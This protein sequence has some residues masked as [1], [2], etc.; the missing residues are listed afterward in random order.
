MTKLFAFLTAAILLGTSI[1]AAEEK[2]GKIAPL[3][4][5]KSTE[6]NYWAFLPRQK[7]TPPTLTLPA[8]KAWVKTPIDAF[9]LAGLKK[10][11]LKPACP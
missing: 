2:T 8:D 9:I 5:Y 3:G 1:W 6:R 11:G 10:A 4:V 7:V